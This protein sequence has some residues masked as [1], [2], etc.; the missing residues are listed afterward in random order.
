MGALVAL[1][2]ATCSILKQPH[3]PSQP[4]ELEPGILVVV[5][6][7]R[8]YNLIAC[9]VAP[10]ILLMDEGLSTERIAVV[11]GYGA[12][13]AASDMFDG[14]AMTSGGFSVPTSPVMTNS[15]FWL[16]DFIQVGCGD[17][18]KH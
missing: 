17:L 15:V 2:A 8:Q 5:F 13:T 18:R 6:P 16:F 9:R 14:S 12:G 7:L 10:T 1:T 4:A 11:N 3:G